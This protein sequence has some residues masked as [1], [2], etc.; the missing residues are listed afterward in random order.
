[1]SSNTSSS[2]DRAFGY[3]NVHA[4]L[5]RH[6]RLPGTPETTTMIDIWL[7]GNRFRLRDGNGRRAVELRAD[8]YAPD[9][10][11]LAPRTVTEFMEAESQ[12]TRPLPGPT[13]V[14]GDLATGLAI[15]HE[16]GQEPRTVSALEFATAAEQLL[17]PEDRR[18]W[19]PAGTGLFESEVT[20]KEHGASYRSIFTWTVSGAF[21]LRR[22][23]QDA[24]NP[25]RFV[26]VELTLL[27]QDCVT[28]ADL[29]GG[30]TVPL[31]KS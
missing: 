19:R 12:T 11:G 9:G 27:E 6:R 26:V 4:R 20:G 8:I 17:V 15:I 25:G 2:S 23:V 13:E 10:F 30:Q 1:M 14:S 31:A 5:R 28:D 21:V 3:P 18:S 7:H 22:R 24:D 29:S 16:A